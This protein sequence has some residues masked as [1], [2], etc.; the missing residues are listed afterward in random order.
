VSVDDQDTIAFRRFSRYFT[1]R[2]GVL[3]DEYLGQSRPLGA[4]RVLF[5]IGSGTSLR[6]LRTR[7]D[8]DPGYLSR[9]VR[10][11]EQDGLV[12]VSAHPDDGRSRVARLTPAGAA[13]L[14]EQ[15]RRA[16]VAAQEILN[17][18]SDEQRSELVTALETAQRLL[19]LAAVRIT[20]VD[21]A[22]S[23]ARDCLAAYVAELRQRFPEGFDAADLVRPDEVRGEAGAFLIAYEDGVPLGCVA[24][25]ILEPGVGEIRN[26][27]VATEA[28]GLGLGRTVLAQ[29]EREAA[30]RGLAVVRLGTHPALT[31]AL[32]MYRTSGYAEIPQYAREAHASYFFEKRLR[33]AV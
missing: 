23:D 21:P 24:L 26:L 13:E 12:Q 27:W 4:A 31:E 30:E 2:V 20:P 9:I 15:S 28:R 17:V 5:E 18:L 33:P 32:Q 1:R 3:A 6:D 25:R 7:L 22:S 29:A 14:E 11:L 16:N 19:R 10:S 8:L